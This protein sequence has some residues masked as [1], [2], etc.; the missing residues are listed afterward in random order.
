P[1]LRTRVEPGGMNYKGFN[2]AVHEMGHNIEQVF[3]LYEVD[4]TLLAGVPNNAFTEAIAF[5]F[6]ARDLELLDI[7]NK[8]AA[9][10]RREQTLSEFWECWEIAGVSLVDIGAWHWMYDHPKATPA[11]LR[12]AVERIANET[13]LK[14]YAGVLGST[15]GKKSTPLLGI[16]SHMI[17][18]PL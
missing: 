9:T 16:Y 7:E 14:Y 17:A 15:E 2:I 4:H 5:L 6:Q 13:W 12:E 1:H 18:Y 3:S 11:E 10:A 8:D